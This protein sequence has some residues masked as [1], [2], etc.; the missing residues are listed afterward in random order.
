MSQKHKVIEKIIDYKQYMNKIRRDNT[1]PLTIRETTMI[2]KV[3]S[4][5]AELKK[6]FNEALK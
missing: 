2:S 3:E 6:Y 5:L 4:M 1:N